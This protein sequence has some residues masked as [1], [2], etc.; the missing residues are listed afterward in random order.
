M[1][2]PM[3]GPVS[4]LPRPAGRTHKLTPDQKEANRVLAIGRA[5]VK[6]GFA[7]LKNWRILIKL[8]TE[9]T[10]ATCL[11][12]ALLVLTNIEINR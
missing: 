10:R 8:R 1:A 3:G 6:H 12:R 5:P 4:R 2:A 7:H 9:P 11:L